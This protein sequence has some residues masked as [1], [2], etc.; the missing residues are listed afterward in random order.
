M[1]KDS[2]CLMVSSLAG[3]ALCENECPENVLD[4]LRERCA[5]K[6]K[7]KVKETLFTVLFA[8]FVSCS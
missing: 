6:R 5:E 7:P 1:R 3:F 8:L 4:F 2:V